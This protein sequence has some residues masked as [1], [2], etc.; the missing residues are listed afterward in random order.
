MSGFFG[1]YDIAGAA[2]DPWEMDAGTYEGAISNV[3]LK[4]GTKVRK[5]EDGNDIE[6]PY[7]GLSVTFSTENK[8]QYQHFFSLPM[9]H[10]KANVVALKRSALKKF[11]K[12]LEIPESRMNSTEPDD[13]KGVACVFTIRKNKNGYWNLEVRLPKGTSIRSNTT[14]SVSSKIDEGFGL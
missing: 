5:D 3:E 14:T 13:L 9:E 10:D 7:R 12:G 6:L 8:G 1:E 2:D 11:M 4:E